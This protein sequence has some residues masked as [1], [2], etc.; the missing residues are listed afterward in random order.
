MTFLQ[1]IYARGGGGSFDAVGHHPYSYPYD[2]SGGQAWN[3]FTQTGFL[4]QIM[5][6]NGDGAKKVWGTES[7]AP[8]GND[9]GRSVD[10]A[11]QAAFVTSYYTSWTTTFGAFISLMPG[12]DGLLHISEAK[13]LAGG[14]RIENVDDVLPVGSKL[15]VEIKEIDSR[16]KISLI[17]VVEDASAADA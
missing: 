4:Y 6:A 11:T 8:T 13:K 14:K 2:P 15:Q 9:P 5:V 12:K 7:G 1:G 3:A 10:E 17:P 16:G